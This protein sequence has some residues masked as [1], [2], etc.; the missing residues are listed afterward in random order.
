MKKMNH[1]GHRDHREIRA[2]KTTAHSFFLC[3]L[4]V[5]CGSIFFAPVASAVPVRLELVAFDHPDTTLDKLE[6][7]RI[8]YN[9]VATEH[10]M[11]MKKVGLDLV[12]WA[13]N[14]RLDG[15]PVFE[16]YHEDE[17][18]KLEYVDRLPIAQ[19]DLAAGKHVLWPGDHAFTIAADGKITTDDSEL[20]VEGNRVRIKCYPVTVRAFRANPDEADLP[21]SM[22][23]AP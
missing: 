11:E 22:R 20:L 7:Q 6:R 8:I 12:G 2:R 19:S 4:C 21:M 15:K 5:L 3:A 9:A 13:R 18:H 16:R 23:L 10:G 17:N 14:V 1:R